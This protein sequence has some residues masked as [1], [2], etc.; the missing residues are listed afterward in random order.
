[1]QLSLSVFLPIS[2]FF[3]A[4]QFFSRFPV[5]SDAARLCYHWR[6]ARP[7]PPPV[8]FFASAQIKI[9]DALTRVIII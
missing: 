5:V 4:A 6:L 8:L 3:W 2:K 7:I 9:P 1:M